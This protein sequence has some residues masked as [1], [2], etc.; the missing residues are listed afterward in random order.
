M[1]NRNIR[2]KLPCTSD[3]LSISPASNLTKEKIQFNKAK[4]SFYYNRSAGP[5]L[6]E[7]QQDDLVMFKKEA[8]SEWRPAVVKGKVNIRSYNVEDERGRIFRRNRKFIHK[9]PQPQRK[10]ETTPQQPVSD[11][12]TTEPRRSAR[13]MKRQ[14]N[15]L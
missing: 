14:S 9:P 5:E 3:K 4:Q 12:N 7:L 2:T 11:T 10:Q 8:D 6:P 13:I 15:R 1:F